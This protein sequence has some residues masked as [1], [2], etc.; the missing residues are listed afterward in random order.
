MVLLPF[1]SCPP[2]GGT[3]GAHVRI[4]NYDVENSRAPRGETEEDSGGQL[5]CPIALKEKIDKL[6][7]TELNV[8]RRE[9]FP[10][11]L[12]NFNPPVR[13]IPRAVFFEESSCFLLTKRKDTGK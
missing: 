5:F 3:T 2:D 8:P 12:H 11:I 10:C 6:P 9:W 13:A 4:T 7:E 1:D